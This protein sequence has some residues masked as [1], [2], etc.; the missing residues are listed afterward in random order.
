MA[1]FELD[2]VVIP[3]KR[4]LKTIEKNYVFF[5]NEGGKLDD[6]QLLKDISLMTVPRGKTAMISVNIKIN[7]TDALAKLPP[8]IIGTQ[9][10]KGEN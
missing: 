5:L 1:D 10:T 7:M 4:V 3:E 6:K 9:N 8:D 2:E